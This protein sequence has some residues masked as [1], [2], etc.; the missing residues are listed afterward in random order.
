[1]LLEALELG[2]RRFAIPSWLNK[3]IFLEGLD[4]DICKSRISNVPIIFLTSQVL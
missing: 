4:R 2:G 3:E 1:M